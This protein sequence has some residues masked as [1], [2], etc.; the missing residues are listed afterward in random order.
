MKRQITLWILVYACRAIAES[1]AE[2][3]NYFG[4]NIHQAHAPF[5]T[6]LCSRLKFHARLRPTAL[7]GAAIL[8]QKRS[9]THKLTERKTP[10]AS[11]GAAIR[12]LTRPVFARACLGPWSRHG[13]ALLQQNSRSAK[14]RI[15][16]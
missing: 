5:A 11:V 12:P 9:A 3:K 7:D 13:C 6:R 10:D 2:I 15:L 8:S 14:T 1:L 4:N 16:E